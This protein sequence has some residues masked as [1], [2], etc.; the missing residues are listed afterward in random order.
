MIGA[1]A[2]RHSLKTPEPNGGQ[3]PAEGHPLPERVRSNLEARFEHD[4]SSVRVHAD[5]GAHQSAEAIGARAFTLG[6]GIWFARGAYADALAGGSSLLAHELA[7]VVQQSRG[8]LSGGGAPAA[9][10]RATLEAHADNAAARVQGGDARIRVGGSS[11]IAVAK[12]AGGSQPANGASILAALKRN[13][14]TGLFVAIDETSQRLAEAGTRQLVRDLKFRADLRALAQGAFLFTILRR[15]WFAKGAPASVVQF[16]DALQARNAQRALDALT[17]FPDLRDPDKV[18]GVYEVVEHVFKAAREHAQIMQLLS[19]DVASVL[20]TGRRSRTFTTLLSL[21]AHFAGQP[22]NVNGLVGKGGEPGNTFT[23]RLTGVVIQPDVASPQAALTRVTHEISNL[24]LQDEFD[25]VYERRNSGGFGSARQ[26]AE[27]MI[28]I[29]EESVVSRHEVAFEL[30]SQGDDAVVDGLVRQ[31]RAGTITRAA[32]DAAVTQR[33]IQ[34]YRGPGGISAVE[35]YERQFRDWQQL[36][37]A[38]TRTP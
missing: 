36:H 2:S 13:D 35:T 18:P 22:G 29:E 10:S 37:A 25:R 14:G 4:F 38:P 7:H 16:E 34:L 9:D 3:A 11:G 1:F 33:V 27:A 20:A 6:S 28:A 5:E 21:A 32:L 17:T 12:Q 24:A 26:F 19:F 31:Q 15:L 8:T 30:N 23:N